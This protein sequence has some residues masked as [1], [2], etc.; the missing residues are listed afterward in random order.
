MYTRF[1]MA[2]CRNW[3]GIAGDDILAAD[4]PVSLYVDDMTPASLARLVFS[5]TLVVALKLT[6]SSLKP[7]SFVY[8]T[9]F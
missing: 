5:S 3:K 8:F 9:S 7:F 2:I 6:L 4:M 1:G